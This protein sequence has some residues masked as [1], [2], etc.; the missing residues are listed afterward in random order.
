MKI[1]YFFSN[2]FNYLKNK[3]FLVFKASIYILNKIFVIFISNLNF[4]NNLFERQLKKILKYLKLNNNCII[5]F[6]T[7]GQ[8]ELYLCT[9]IIKKYSE[10][11]WI[12]IFRRELFQDYNDNSNIYEH[13]KF[14]L[15]LN[16]IKKISNNFK[17]YT[18]TNLLTNQ[19]N[20]LNVVR[21]ETLPIPLPEIKNKKN[22]NEIIQ[23]S[24]LGDARDE[25][26]YQLLDKLI[27]DLDAA[28]IDFN[29]IKFV[30]QSNFN[31]DNGEKYTR[32]AKSN[33][34]S[35]AKK[36]ENIDIINKSIA[37]DEYNKILN[38]TDILLLPYNNK[39]YRA[40]SSGVFAEAQSN[41]IP[42]IIMHKTWMSDQIDGYNQK[43]Y[44]TLLS[45]KILQIIKL[46]K[47]I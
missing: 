47:K 3:I 6:P 31:V 35:L 7:I 14:S 26:N 16:L 8:N 43:Y 46:K 42:S 33:L 23:L 1:Y 38:N 24:Y 40:R 39:N 12:F 32:V 21:F 9:K 4:K 28:S 34:L 22:D 30:I 17:F 44:Q 41:G 18:D 11:K 5:F 15:T 36:F 29:K 20:R 27:L 19:Y 37:S 2:F 10:L 25:K 45:S 13:N